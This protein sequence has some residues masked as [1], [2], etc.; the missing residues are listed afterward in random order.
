M[1]GNFILFFGNFGD[2][3]PQKIHYIFAFV[4]LISHCILVVR[5]M[6]KTRYNDCVCFGGGAG[7]PNKVSKSPHFEEK[8]SEVA[9]FR[10]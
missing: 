6:A 10:Q 4:I 8:N 5:N 2:W 7:I 9:R 3:K 1:G